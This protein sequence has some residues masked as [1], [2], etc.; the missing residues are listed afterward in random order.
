M[1]LE[2]AFIESLIIEAAKFRGQAAEGPDKLDPRGA[3]ERLYEA[4]APGKLQSFLGFRLYLCKGISDY[5]EVRDQL[6][7]AKRGKSKVTDSVGGIGGAT[8][9]I[10]TFQGMFRRRHNETSE[11]HIGSSAITP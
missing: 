10:A 9:E 8:Y 2:C 11:T 5:Q 6:V 4:E 7:P 1:L 3:E